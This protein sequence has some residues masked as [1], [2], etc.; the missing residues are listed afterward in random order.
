MTA[1]SK[2]AGTRSRSKAAS[3]L[4]PHRLVRRTLGSLRR[5]WTQVYAPLAQGVQMSPESEISKSMAPESVMDGP[6]V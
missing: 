4:V 6:R 2:H 3:V 5:R 1:R